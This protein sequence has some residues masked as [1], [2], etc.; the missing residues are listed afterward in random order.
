MNSSLSDFL[1]LDKNYEKCLIKSGVLNMGMFGF[2]WKIIFIVIFLL[3]LQKKLK[4]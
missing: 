4:N 2:F 1:N 3:L